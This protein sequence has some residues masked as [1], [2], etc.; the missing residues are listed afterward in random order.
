MGSQGWG[1]SV[2][3]GTG[4]MN[5]PGLLAGRDL[6]ALPGLLLGEPGRQGLSRHL[7]PGSKQLLFGKAGAR[8]HRATIAAS[9]SHEGTALQHPWV[10]PGGSW[11]RRKG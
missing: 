10:S 8:H 3:G 4:V 7:L 9:P 1:C 6:A 11:V 2:P 5:W